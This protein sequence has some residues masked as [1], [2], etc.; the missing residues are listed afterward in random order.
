[1]KDSHLAE[2]KFLTKNP[3][4][5]GYNDFVYKIVIKQTKVRN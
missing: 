3:G 2:N 1:M 5:T 4:M